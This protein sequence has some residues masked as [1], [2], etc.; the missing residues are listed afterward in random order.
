[1]TPKKDP[2]AR[3]EVQNTNVLKRKGG[4]EFLEGIRSPVKQPRWT[5]EE[6]YLIS[7]IVRHSTR[8]RV[9]MVS[10]T[11]SKIQERTKKLSLSMKPFPKIRAK[12]KHLRPFEKFIKPKEDFVK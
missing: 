11:Y 1:M 6:T 5:N 9:L 2:T 3:R 10:N 12:M 8:N 4:I 7:Q